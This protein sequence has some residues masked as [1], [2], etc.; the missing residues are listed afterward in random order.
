MSYRGGCSVGFPVL[1]SMELV[2]IERVRTANGEPVAYCI[3]KMP[4]QIFPENF[5][6][7]HESIYQLLE[8]VRT[9]KLPML[10]RISSRLAI[11]RK[12]LRFLNVILKPL[13]LC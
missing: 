1:W 13:C 9:E 12:S 10:L 3:D 2:V 11:M 5:T 6:H 4:A 8:T 7:E